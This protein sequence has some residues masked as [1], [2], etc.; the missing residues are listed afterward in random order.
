MRVKLTY[1]VEEDEVLKEAAALLSHQAPFLNKC[2][3]DF[4]QL[5]SILVAE[6]EFNTDLFQEKVESYRKCLSK[7]DVRVFEVLEIVRAY[8]E[9]KKF[10]PPPEE[11]ASLPMVT[12]EKKPDVP[13]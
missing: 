4:N 11:E 7:L 13:A 1:T 12:E 9:Y 6:E 10:G 2:I 8:E 5:N 3:E